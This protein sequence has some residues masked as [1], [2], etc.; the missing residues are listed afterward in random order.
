MKTLCYG[1]FGANI[2]VEILGMLNIDGVNRSVLH[3]FQHSMHL[4][5]SSAPS[6]QIEEIIEISIICKRKCDR[7]EGCKFGIRGLET[8]KC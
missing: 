4:I 8:T 2:I 7:V 1:H 3:N 5:M 6:I